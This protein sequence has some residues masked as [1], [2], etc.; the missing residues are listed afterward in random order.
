[1]SRQDKIAEKAKRKTTLRCLKEKKESRL[2]QLKQEY[3]KNVREI[4][5]EY[6][7][8]PERLKAKYAAVDFS[9]SEK[10]RR[11]S[12]RKI[13]AAKKKIEFAE[14]Q[15]IFTLGEEISSSIIQGIGFALFIAGISILDT[16]GITEGMDFRSLTIVCYSLF[17]SC[18]ILMYLF[19]LLSHALT[20]ITA[21]DV[22]SRLTHVFSY[23]IIGFAYTAY[24]IT[25]IQGVRGWI[26]FGIVWALVFTGILLYSIGGIKMEKA[27][28]VL[29]V[30]SGSIG[31]IFAKE[32]F[33]VLS[34]ISFTMLI[35]AGVFYIGGTVFYYLRKIKF[36]HLVGNII[37]L[38]GSIFLFFSLFYI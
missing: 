7:K 22:F 33:E 30:V 19:S 17:G 24:T 1:M 12:E 37:F 27:C 25:K 34:P 23:L 32:L 11:R 14:K 31:L 16:L 15:R 36:M 18:M 38:A 13:E 35:L 5:I 21:K 4:S 10:A 26:L 2:H 6:A 28:L 8:D 9:K 3:E 29:Y 20:N